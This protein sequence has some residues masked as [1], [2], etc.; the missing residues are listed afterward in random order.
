[1]SVLYRGT[2]ASDRSYIAEIYHRIRETCPNV[3][4]EYGDYGFKLIGYLVD[5]EGYTIVSSIRVICQP[6]RQDNGQP[7]IVANIDELVKYWNA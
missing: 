4:L 2:C 6:A 5:D 7:E 3:L 1:M